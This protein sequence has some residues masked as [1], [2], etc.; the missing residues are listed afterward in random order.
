MVVERNAVELKFVFVAAINF[1]RAV[2]AISA[3]RIS[4]V[5][6]RRLDGDVCPRR[7]D[8]HGIDVASGCDGVAIEFQA[9]VACDFGV[10]NVVVESGVGVVGGNH[11]GCFRKVGGVNFYLLYFHFFAI[12]LARAVVVA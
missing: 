4:Y 6:A 8:G 2:V 11:F 5:F 3:E 10:F 7:G 12:A 9:D 1:Y